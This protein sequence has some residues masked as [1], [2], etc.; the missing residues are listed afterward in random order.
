MYDIMVSLYAFLWIL[1]VQLHAKTLLIDLVDKIEQ[2]CLV[3][4]C[5]GNINREQ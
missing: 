5:G 2:N 3:P 1:L 4:M